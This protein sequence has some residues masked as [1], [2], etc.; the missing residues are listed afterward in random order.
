MLRS[1]TAMVALGSLAA[2]L[3]GAGCEGSSDGDTG[4]RSCSSDS[5]CRAEER[6]ETEAGPPTHPRIAV[7]C[8]YA[9]CGSMG[10]CA[11][12][13]VCLPAASAPTPQ[14]SPFCGPNVCVQRCT[15]TS[16]AQGQVCRDTG[17]CGVPQCDEPGVEACPAHW[18]CDPALAKTEPLL[19][20]DSAVERTL[21]DDRAIARGCVRKRCDVADGHMCR[22]FWACAPGETTGGSGCVPMP[23]EETG[24]C[25]TDQYICEPTS[26]NSRPAGVDHFGCVFRNCEEGL[27]CL[28]PTN[29]DPSVAYCDFSAPNADSS[30]CALRTCAE[31]NRCVE[32]FV[33]DPS[34]PQA[35]RIGCVPDPAAGGSG[36]GGTGSGAA[37][38]NGGDGGATNNGGTSNG[39]TTSAGGT[40]NDAGTTSTGG[41]SG[42]NGETSTGGGRCVPR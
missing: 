25:V 8:L 5:E 42:S 38:G 15:Q 20:S 33:C 14:S 26:S 13:F 21:E 4:D 30:G 6:C 34:S 40:T 23:C 31:G 24:H 3:A 11:E 2:I 41:S 22:E 9:Q 1:K 7:P 39:G 18:R 28:A 10:Q 12:G 36:S 37:S 27:A 32:T 16:C 17:V 19:D 35:N 29:S